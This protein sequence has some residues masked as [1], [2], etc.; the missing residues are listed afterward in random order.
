MNEED[1]ANAYAN[2]YEE[3]Q[4][5]ME[6]TMENK[7]EDLKFRILEALKHIRYSVDDAENEV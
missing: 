4:N 1:Y 7:I 3:G 6:T 5:D 2:G